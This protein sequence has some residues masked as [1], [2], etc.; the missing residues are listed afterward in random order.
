M[1]EGVDELVEEG[2]EGIPRVVGVDGERR[3][4]LGNSG[5]GEEEVVD[6]GHHLEQVG[7]STVA[8]AFDL[9]KTNTCTKCKCTKHLLSAL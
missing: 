1:D 6:D 8:V 5:R 7:G 2:Q 3:E 9:C 4:D